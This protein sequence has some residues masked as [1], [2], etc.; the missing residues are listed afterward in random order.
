MSKFKARP[1]WQVSGQGG[2]TRVHSIG[3]GNGFPGNG[4]GVAISKDW[5]FVEDVP[6]RDPAAA[7]PA[8]GLCGN[9]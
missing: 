8:L 4:F 5:G 2:V 6:L 3:P 7:G 9:G 1:L